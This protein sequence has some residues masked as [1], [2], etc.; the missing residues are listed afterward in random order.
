MTERILTQVQAP[1]LGFLQ[2]PRFDTGA[3]RG[4][5]APGARNKFDVSIFEPKLFWD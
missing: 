5:I 1:K 2:S 4:Q 3:Y